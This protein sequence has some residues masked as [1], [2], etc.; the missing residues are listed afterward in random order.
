MMESWFGKLKNEI[1]YNMEYKDL[2]EVINT[3]SSYI[4]FYNE[5]REVPRFLWSKKE[6]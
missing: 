5:K 6:K 4:K 1:I 2:K 3:I